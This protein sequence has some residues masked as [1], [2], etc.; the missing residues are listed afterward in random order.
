MSGATDALG[1]TP[2]SAHDGLAVEGVAAIT[3][4]EGASPSAIDCSVRSAVSW[5]VGPT[6]VGGAVEPG[7][8][9]RVV[10]VAAI[11]EVVVDTGRVEV[12]VPRLACPV[13]PPHAERVTTATRPRNGHMDMGCR[14][15][16]TWHT[17]AC[18]CRHQRPAAS[19]WVVPLVPDHR[20]SRATTARGGLCA[21]FPCS[22]TLG[23][24]RSRGLPAVGVV[25]GEYFVGAAELKGL[26][27]RAVCSSWCV[28]DAQ[29]SRRLESES[30][31][32]AGIPEDHDQW[33]PSLAQLTK[34]FRHESGADAL[35]LPV[36]SNRQWGDPGDGNS[37]EASQ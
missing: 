33:V 27:V 14:W 23:T 22:G 3:K 11:G 24:S 29:W 25:P 1:F 2:N 5:S 26:E 8:E 34:E 12:G 16:L 13:P 30:S 15:A 17:I 37:V 4:L 10:A 6:V 21:S 20:R 9:G 32:V 18:N 28:V 7:D 36:R 35:A 31:V 19:M